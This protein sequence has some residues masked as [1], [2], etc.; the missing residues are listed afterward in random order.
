MI[1]KELKYTNSAFDY[2][3]LYTYTVIVNIAVYRKYTNVFLFPENEVLF[4]S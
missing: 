4:D 2:I 1:G 3:V